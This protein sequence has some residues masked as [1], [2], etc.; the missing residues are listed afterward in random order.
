MKIIINTQRYI[1]RNLN[2]W[3]PI[4]DN[5]SC[6]MHHPNTSVLFKEPG[7]TRE[8]SKAAANDALTTNAADPQLPSHGL[9]V[10]EAK[11]ATSVQ[12]RLL[13]G[14]RLVARFNIDHTVAVIREFIDLARL[15]SSGVYQLQ[16]VGFPP[17]KLTNPAQTVQAAAHISTDPGIYM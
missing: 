11:P 12:L 6:C 8:T 17:V 3:D 1:I 10:D 7:H 5:V 14:T 2:F 15:G 9:I 13:D 4:L 16:T